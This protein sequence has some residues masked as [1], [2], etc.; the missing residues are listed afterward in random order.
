RLEVFMRE[1]AKFEVDSFKLE[2]SSH[3]WYQVYKHKAKLRGETPE[4]SSVVED[5][6]RGGGGGKNR[7]RGLGAHHHRDRQDD[8]NGLSEMDYSSVMGEAATP[9]KGNR[10]V[11]SKSQQGMLELIRRFVQRELPKVAA[12]RHK[13]PMQFLPGPATELDN[14]IVKRAAELLGIHVGHEY[15]HDGAL[16]L[17]VAMGSAKAIAKLELEDTSSSSAED[18]E[19]RASSGAI[20]FVSSGSTAFQALGGLEDVYDDD[21]SDDVDVEGKAAAAAA[22]EQLV[23]AV[24]AFVESGK[25]IHDPAAVA[26]YVA[27]RLRPLDDVLV[28]ADSE[29]AL[30]TQTGD[31]S[32]FWQRFELWKA[33]YYGAK[34]DIVYDAPDCA[35]EAESDSGGGGGGSSSTASGQRFRRPAATVEPMCRS[36]IG[37][38]QWVLQYYYRG[39]QSWSWYY[40]YHYA[41]CI[42]DMCA[43]LA[44]YRVAGFAA[45]EPY[46]PYE[47]LMCVLPPFSRK[48]LPAGLRALMVDAHSPIRDMYPTSF[49]VDMNGKKMAWEAVVLIDFVDAGRIRAAMQPALQQLSDDERR[50]NSRGTNMVYSYAPLSAHDDSDDNGANGGAPVYTAPANLRFPAIRPLRCKGMVYTMPSLRTGGTGLGGGDQRRLISGLIGGAATRGR[51]LSGF[52][53]LFTAAHHAQ[54]ALNGTEVFG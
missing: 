22:T 41:P 15:A 54:L 44:A 25:D 38:L 1:I 9:I 12:A 36:Y 32:D 17:Y 16:T 13:V 33:A 35:S 4:E 21:D 8:S 26:E 45:D 39:C 2:V 49:S 52:S 27:M 53:S 48:L 34:L 28:V 47:Q 10:L 14:L 30:Y 11:I 24:A 6:G 51:M 29:L 19:S 40:P 5:H 43:N 18:G 31:V 20:N 37:S 3:Q 50:R 23:P 42:S 46:T 7:R